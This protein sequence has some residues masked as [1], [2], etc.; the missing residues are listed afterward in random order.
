MNPPVRLIDN[1]FSDCTREVMRVTCADGARCGLPECPTC[2]LAASSEYVNATLEFEMLS[3]TR[4]AAWAF[5]AAVDELGKLR[6]WVARQIQLRVDHQAE[7]SGERVREI[8]LQRRSI[9]SGGAMTPADVEA[10]DREADEVSCNYCGGSE[11][12]TESP[13]G[14]RCREDR[15]RELEDMAAARADRIHDEARDADLFV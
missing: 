5:A 11:H 10:A 8:E 2:G 6:A 13:A 4:G 14:E 15:E 9:S 7:A 3:R 1:E 12:R